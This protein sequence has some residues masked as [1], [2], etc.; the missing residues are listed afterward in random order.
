MKSRWRTPRWTI[1]FVLSTIG[2]GW[3]AGMAGAS[4]AQAPAPTQPPPQAAASDASSEL[5]ALRDEVAR[6]RRLVPSQSHAMQDVSYHYTNLWF[7]G[8]KANWPLAQFY[9]NETRSH[10]GWAVRIIP[11]RKLTSGEVELEGIRQAFDSGY[12]AAVQQAID[13]RSTT[14]F[15][16]SYKRSLEG[17][18]ACHKA[19]EK[20]FLRPQVPT[21]PETQIVNFDPDATWPE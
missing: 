19:S 21:Q 11:K 20:P 7:A 4:R 17:C 1:P 15:A 13:A 10:I 8:A 2:V 16:D 3:G 9:L 14:R 5:A 18:Y 12:L 6:L